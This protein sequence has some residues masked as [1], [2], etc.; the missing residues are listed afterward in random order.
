MSGLTA[1]AVIPIVRLAMDLLG[2]EY[3]GKGNADEASRV[4]QWLALQGGMFT[5]NELLFRHEVL[6]FQDDP[7]FGEKVFY[8]P[9]G[10]RVF[11]IALTIIVLS[12]GVF[13]SLAPLKQTELVR[14]HLNP[15]QG[16][17]KVFSPSV[18]IV[19]EVL[20]EEGQAVRKGQVLAR[21]RRG[22]FDA[23][24]HAA[25]DYSVSQIDVQIT[26]QAQQKALIISRSKL[27]ERQLRAQLAV[28]QEELD[29]MR[30]QLGIVEKRYA[31]GER[32]LQRQAH[33]LA[34]GQASSAQY[35][36]V[37]DSHFALAQTLQGLHAQIKSR[38][39][40]Q[41]RLQ[42]QLAVE[43]FTRD[44]Q[45]FEFENAL[46]QLQS[47]RKE[48]EV[49]SAFSLTAPRAGIVGNLLLPRGASVDTRV[50]ILTILPQQLELQALLYVPSRALGEL[51]NQQQVMLAF[52]AYPSRVF[53]YFPAR[54]EG[55]A[56]TVVDPRE[57]IFPL[58][59]REPVYL[60]RAIPELQAALVEDGIRLRSGMQFSAY[61]L[62][63]QQSLLQRLMSPLQRLRSRV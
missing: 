42:Q 48:L 27:N 58:E 45:F 13:A 49:E 44:A 55:I 31:L 11:V 40:T 29:A 21:V 30:A 15:K 9:I 23:T 25:L 3:N 47:R 8:Q 35:E 41:L 51:A 5:M 53:G 18:G 7:R 6:Q 16:T 28:A 32:E 37:L 50:P 1:V 34:L 63:G 52:D 10:L 36:R 19:T 4:Q 59:V 46:A 60:V 33:L 26:A 2:R 39:G 17:A 56:D 57:H 24:G 38:A 22:A 14:G 20:V 62:T 61:V 54:I 12:F 43:P